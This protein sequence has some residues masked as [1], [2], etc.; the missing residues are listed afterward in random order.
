[1]AV[2]VGS[3]CFAVSERKSEFPVSRT[4]PKEANKPELKMGKVLDTAG[5]Q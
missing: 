5:F 4:I 1:M 3:N 2:F